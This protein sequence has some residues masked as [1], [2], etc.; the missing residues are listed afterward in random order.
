[1]RLYLPTHWWYYASERNFSKKKLKIFRKMWIFRKTTIF[2][3]LELLGETNEESAPLYPILLAGI[4]SESCLFYAIT[5]FCLFGYLIIWS[6]NRLELYHFRKII[7][8]FLT[9]LK[10]RFIMT[11]IKLFTK[12]WIVQAK[13][14]GFSVLLTFG[15]GYTPLLHSRLSLIIHH[16]PTSTSSSTTSLT[17]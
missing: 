12:F 8:E 4:Q 3:N 6:R 11:C 9:G 2:L 1:M 13:I 16:C 17:S 7:T 5:R 10:F 14:Y 15:T